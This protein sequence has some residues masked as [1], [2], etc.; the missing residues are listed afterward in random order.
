MKKSSLFLI[1]SIIISLPIF[2]MET[3]KER[4]IYPVPKELCTPAE[5]GVYII[6][7]NIYASAN[8]DAE[9]TSHILHDISLTN[10]N[11]YKALDEE[12]N[13]PL[14]ARNI[15]IQF[16]E[17]GESLK[18]PGALQCFALSKQLYDKNITPEAIEQLFKKGAVLNYTNDQGYGPLHCWTQSDDK[19]SISIVDKLIALGADPNY[20]SLWDNNSFLIAIKKQKPDKLNAL[21]NYYTHM[22][23]KSTMCISI[24]ID[25]LESYY[26]GS[27]HIMGYEQC[28]KLIDLFMDN[29][30]KENCNIGL[31]ACIKAEDPRGKLRIQLMQKLI[32]RGA[33]TGLA[34][35][36]LLETI[37][38]WGPNY[39][40]SR[41][42][43]DFNM[44]CNTG[45]FD[46]EALITLEG[47]GQLFDSLL[48][49]L[50]SNTPK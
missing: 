24:W 6:T 5:K 41:F 14:T 16:G 13:D 37:T 40:H 12:R 50:K 25:I 49:M 43:Q 7:Q 17:S 27:E 45:A 26:R 9:C 47:V 30:S 46:K 36:Y 3:E 18:F 20:G 35:Q 15:I 10:K 44:L 22:N 4:G 42:I 33:N 39:S 19:I 31:M 32:D 21:L 48:I 8:K 29:T 23:G 1:A 2:S 34:L 28:P 38:L 11:V